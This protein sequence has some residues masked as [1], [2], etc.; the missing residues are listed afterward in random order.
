MMDNTPLGYYSCQSDIVSTWGQF[1]L[2]SMNQSVWK[3]CYFQTCA[4]E[5]HTARYG[6]VP[7]ILAQFVRPNDT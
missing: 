6:N 7:D 5:F 2:H 3:S 1:D 4:Q